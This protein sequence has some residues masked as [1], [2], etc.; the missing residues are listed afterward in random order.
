MC[1]LTEGETKEQSL[2]DHRLLLP[3][4]LCSTLSGL[5]SRPGNPRKD[6][7]PTDDKAK[8]KDNEDGE[9]PYLPETKAG[10][11]EVEVEGDC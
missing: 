7:R 3:A 2:R 11:V 5:S 1:R 6:L 9:A 8:V 4:L 10:K